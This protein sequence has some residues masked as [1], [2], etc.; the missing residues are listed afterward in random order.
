MFGLI[1]CIHSLV[2]KLYMLQLFN[3]YNNL[4]E[5]LLNVPETLQYSLWTA[6]HPNCLTNNIPVQINVF[7]KISKSRIHEHTISLRFLGM[8]TEYT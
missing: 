6:A 7:K 5:I 4:E 2:Y 8:I 3:M 1:V